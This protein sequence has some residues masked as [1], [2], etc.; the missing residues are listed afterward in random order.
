MQIPTRIQL[1][2]SYLIIC[3]AVVQTKA[4]RRDPP[5]PPPPPP[6]SHR[7]YQ[8]DNDSWDAHSSKINGDREKHEENFRQQDG[9]GN[10]SIGGRG[11]YGPDDF[12]RPGNS[13]STPLPP[14]PRRRPPPPPPPPPQQSKNQMN[15]N[16]EHS[17]VNDA[18]KNPDVNG[19]SQPSSTYDP[20]NYQFPSK[21]SE[22]NMNQ[23][24]KNNYDPRNDN[25]QDSIPETGWTEASPTEM[26]KRYDSREEETT[27]FASPRRDVITRYT[28]TT[29]GKLKLGISSAC[30]GGMIGGF[31]GKSIFHQGYP[32]AIAVSFLFWAMNFLR[33]AYGEMSRAIGMAFLLLFRR[34]Y[35]I[36]RRYKT[37]PHV[38]AILG[39]KSR[40]PFPPIMNNDDDDG[41]TENPWKYQPVHRDDPKFEM[42]KS[43]ACMALIGS[44]CGGN[45]PLLPTWIGSSAGAITF[46]FV[47]TTKNSR[48]DLVRTMGMRVVALI[49]EAIEI[50]YDLNIARKTAVVSG[51]IVDKL[52]ILDRKHRIKDK[53]WSGMSWVYDKVSTATSRVQNDIQQRQDNSNNE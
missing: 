33:N 20:I 16:R 44:F 12:R 26:E 49:G 36:R 37:G 30:V 43:L 34:L 51:K 23:T 38:K 40:Q 9:R 7:Y 28:S 41:S 35:G 2:S 39:M 24:P 4:R 53:V 21:S 14:P 18:P 25:D 1:L 22:T 42:V 5:P 45:M 31:V 3:L 27:Q 11:N 46:A 48:G 13:N 29:I 19:K 50:N 10:R 15:I 8:D 17:F 47:A 52:L 6:A 32:F